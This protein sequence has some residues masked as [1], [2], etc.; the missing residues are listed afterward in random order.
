MTYPISG[1]KY[2]EPSCLSGG[3][4]NNGSGD[5]SVYFLIDGADEGSYLSNY[6]NAKIDLLLD[7]DCDRFRQVSLH[8]AKL[9]N[10]LFSHI[11][12]RLHDGN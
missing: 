1:T 4:E 3:K 8:S 10:I 6:F 2:V 11:S 7:R 9:Q 12:R 5:Y